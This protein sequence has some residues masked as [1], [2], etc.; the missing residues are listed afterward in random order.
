[1]SEPDLRA[2]IKVAIARR[3]HV[4]PDVLRAHHRLAELEIGSFQFLQL[5][6]EIEDM[7]RLELTD[8]EMN[9]VLSCYTVGELC[10]TFEDI[11]RM[12][13]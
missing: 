10:Q 8:S 11:I 2:P 7:M 12:S 9:K 13:E 4:E 1:M 6:L 3:A 5:V